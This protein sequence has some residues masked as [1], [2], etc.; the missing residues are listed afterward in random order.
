MSTKKQD[1]QSRSTLA[2]GSPLDGRSKFTA[3]T[4]RTPEARAKAVAAMR[5]LGPNNRNSRCWSLRSPN[6]KTYQFRNLGFWV[7][8]N[9]QLFDQDE[10]RITA[11]GKL[12]IECALQ[13]LSPRRKRCRETAH[14]WRWHINKE[15]FDSYLANTPV[16][17]PGQKP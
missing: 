15:E 9:K 17:Q 16:R 3:A 7:R 8:E 12:L 1:E 14:G 4:C 2:T 13:E 5:K 10:M 11:S 6:G